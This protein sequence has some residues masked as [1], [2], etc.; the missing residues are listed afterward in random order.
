VTIIVV[1]DCARPDPFALSR[2]APPGPA[3]WRA[4][5]PLVD[6]KLLFQ[7]LRQG[8]RADAC[9]RVDAAAGR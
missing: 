4:A 1:C 8:L 9:I 3:R 2:S 6:Y 7:R 5:G